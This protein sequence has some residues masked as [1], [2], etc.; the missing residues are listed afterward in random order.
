MLADCGNQRKECNMDREM[1]IKGLYKVGASEKDVLDALYNYRFYK[2]YHFDLLFCD[3]LIRQNLDALEYVDFELSKFEVSKPLD[4]GT[5]FALIK[6][7]V[8]SCF[9]P[10]NTPRQKWKYLDDVTLYLHD[11]K[12]VKE[13]FVYTRMLL[14]KQKIDTA[15]A[16]ELGS[17]FNGILS[18][19]PNRYADTLFQLLLSLRHEMTEDVRKDFVHTVFD[20]SVSWLSLKIL[21]QEITECLDDE[22]GSAAYLCDFIKN[23][24]FQICLSGSGSAKHPSSYIKEVII[25]MC[26]YPSLLREIADLDRDSLMKLYDIA[27]LSQSLEAQKIT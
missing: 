16:E 6:Y 5:A 14:Q 7:Y 13:L 4:K 21:V 26:L 8:R 2:D 3:N 9:S 23:R 24:I 12:W 25:Q 1:Q 15:I 22:S 10:N 20:K 17:Y 27:V 11:S 19:L 18:V